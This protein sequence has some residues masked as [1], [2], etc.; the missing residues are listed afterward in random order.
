MATTHRRLFHISL[1]ADPNLAH[2]ILLLATD[3][4][5]DVKVHAAPLPAA[6]KAPRAEAAEATPTPPAEASPPI[7]PNLSAREWIMHVLSSRAQISQKELMGRGL[8]YGFS[9]SAVSGGCHS[10]L[11]DKTIKRPRAGV[12]ARGRAFHLREAI[13]APVANGRANGHDTVS[14]KPNIAST[15]S[16]LMA[17]GQQ[18]S[19]GDIREH[20]V[21]AGFA[22]ASVPDALNRMLS[23]K[24]LRR[25]APATYAA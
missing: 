25:V 21:K 13:T 9:R 19:I 18:H 4:A 12:Y 7:P 10:A 2:E 17:D 3:R 22:R 5:Y 8:S 6:T 14:S 11:K 15:I 24:Q 23:R 16:G 1:T 20:I